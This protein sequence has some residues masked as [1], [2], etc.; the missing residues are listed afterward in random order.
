MIFNFSH[1]LSF[2]VIINFLFPLCVFQFIKRIKRAYKHFMSI[3]CVNSFCELNCSELNVSKN[4]GVELFMSCIVHE[5]NVAE[6]N[7]S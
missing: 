7:C 3:D 4:R 5:L 6:S 1:R 2:N